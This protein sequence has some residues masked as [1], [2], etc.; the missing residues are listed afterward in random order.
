MDEL[1]P[2]A[3]NMHYSYKED[4][5]DCELPDIAISMKESWRDSNCARWHSCFT[6]SLQPTSRK[7]KAW[8]LVDRGSLVNIFCDVMMELEHIH[9]WVDC[10]EALAPFPCFNLGMSMWGLLTIWKHLESFLPS[11]LCFGGGMTQGLLK[12]V[13]NS[14]SLELSPRL[15]DQI[16]N[17]GF[18]FDPVLL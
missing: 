1:R 6:I 10:T 12:R 13:T 18:K 3:G 14:L 15:L 8:T 9:Q 4:D 7:A 11:R 5:T 17:S 2:T 16:L